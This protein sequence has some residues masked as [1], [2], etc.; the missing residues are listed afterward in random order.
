MA[1]LTIMKVIMMI[2]FK[3]QAIGENNED[4]AYYGDDQNGDDNEHDDSV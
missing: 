2:R 4:D 3:K 1:R